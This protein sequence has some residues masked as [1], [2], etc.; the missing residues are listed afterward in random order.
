MQKEFLFRKGLK[1]LKS[2]KKLW[3]ITF[4]NSR[5][6]RNMDSTSMIIRMKKLEFFESSFA[7]WRKKDEISP[8]ALY[9]R[10]LRFL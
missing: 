9:L 6:E 8:T 10:F 7:K 3:M 4:H 2:V 1:W 5:K